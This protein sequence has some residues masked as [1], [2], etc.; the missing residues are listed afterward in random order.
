MRRA[1]D[2]YGVAYLLAALAVALMIVLV[3]VRAP[4]R[5]TA[6]RHQKG[7][8]FFAIPPPKNGWGAARSGGLY[9]G[10]APGWGEDRYE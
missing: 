4:V 1:D 5:D 9:G 6:R 8:R 2:G 3:L 10:T 7:D